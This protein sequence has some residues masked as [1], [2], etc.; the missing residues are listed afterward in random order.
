MNAADA[1]VD[2]VAAGHGARSQA[3]AAAA[4]L[5]IRIR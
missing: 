3:R 2:T 1:T 4:L 5:F